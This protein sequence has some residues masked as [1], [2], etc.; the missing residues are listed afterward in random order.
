M[1]R[2]VGARAGPFALVLASPALRARQT[3]QL[4]AGRLDAIE[5]G[6]LPDMSAVLPLE[7]FQALRSLADVG[8]A[9]AREPELL[10]FAEAQL[11]A[12]SELARVG[13]EERV[14][15]ISH[16]GVLEL[17]AACVAER[18]GTELDAPMFGYCEGIALTFRAG[19]P[20]A[21]EVLRVTG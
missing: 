18:L 4:I 7:K 15:A 2:E 17:V 10:A 13:D 11:R 14:L 3:A 6:L 9:L 12:W 5:P 19:A 16:G 20:A 8:T 21:L 1:A